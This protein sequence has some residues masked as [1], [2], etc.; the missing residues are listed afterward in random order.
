[1]SESTNRHIIATNISF[2]A[3]ILRSS[4]Y[5]SANLTDCIMWTKLA[6]KCWSSTLTDQNALGRGKTEHF[7]FPW[8]R[9]NNAQ[10]A[11]MLY[12]NVKIAAV[13]E[14]IMHN[15][16]LLL[17]QTFTSAD[18]RLHFRLWRNH[19]DYTNTTSSLRQL[20]VSFVCLWQI[21][22]LLLQRGVSTISNRARGRESLLGVPWWSGWKQIQWSSGTFETMT[23]LPSRLSG[24]GLPLMPLQVLFQARKSRW[25]RKW[26]KDG[27]TPYREVGVEVV[28]PVKKWLLVYGALQSQSCHDCCLHTSLIQH[29]RANT[30]TFTW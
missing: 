19:G 13:Q 8:G 7:K 29:L 22:P 5:S 28:F 1:M 18:S 14:I 26:G 15:K 20:Y 30:E 9:A 17:C 2:I 27:R 25:H 16:T 23:R 10:H 21:A 11:I 4:Y 24:K 6:V 12:H 3:D